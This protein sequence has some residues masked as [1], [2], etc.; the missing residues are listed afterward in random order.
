[1][2]C[3]SVAKA[4]KVRILHRHQQSRRPCDQRERGPGRFGSS[5]AMSDRI[6][7]ST[8]VYGNMAETSPCSDLDRCCELA[9]MR[10]GQLATVTH[11][12]SC[13]RMG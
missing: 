10:R 12:I 5:P 3:K 1:M 7:L 8:A 11:G 9:A 6:R 13:R 2:D 4:T